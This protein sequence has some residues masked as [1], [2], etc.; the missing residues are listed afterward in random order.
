MASHPSRNP[1]TPAR[2]AGI[3]IAIAAILTL[4]GVGFY[5]ASGAVADDPGDPVS[6]GQAMAAAS[7]LLLVSAYISVAA[8]ILFAVGAIMLAVAPSHTDADGTE[9]RRIAIPGLWLTLVLG[10]LLILPFD[11]ALPRGLIPLAQADPTT[12]VFAAIYETIN[13]V[14]SAGLAVF[15]VATTALFIHQAHTADARRARVGWR[16]MSGISLLAVVVAG[17]LIIERPPIYLVPTVFLTWFGLL[18]LGVRMSMSGTGKEEPRAHHGE[19][20]A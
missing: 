19:T 3:I 15:Y 6:A 4:T 14:H 17:G 8:N 9:A 2:V 12:I 20:R 5:F 10:V 16:I 18:W 7:D 13:F 1:P 11:L